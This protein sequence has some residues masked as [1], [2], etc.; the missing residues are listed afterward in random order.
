MS[1]P[2]ISPEELEQLILD[3][4]E[5]THASRDEDSTW[6]SISGDD[7]GESY[8]FIYAEGPARVFAAAPALAL[9]VRTLRAKLADLEE[10][11][12]QLLNRIERY[13]DALAAIE[14]GDHPSGDAADLRRVAYVALMQ[15]ESE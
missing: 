4:V 9:E 6:W 8:G 3:V 14:G 10:L 13:G 2:P 12:G 1:T 5:L 15:L 11:Q 7:E